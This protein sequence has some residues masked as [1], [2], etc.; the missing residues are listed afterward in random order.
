MENK[1][2]WNSYGNRLKTP[3]VG[4]QI[5]QLLNQRSTLVKTV[6]GV[7]YICDYDCWKAMLDR[8]VLQS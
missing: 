8:L 5:H 4:K 7:D 3:R 2:I 6:C 1:L